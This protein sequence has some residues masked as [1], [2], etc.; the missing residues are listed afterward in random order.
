M[1]IDRAF[2][3]LFNRGFKLS[4]LSRQAGFFVIFLSVVIM[5]RFAVNIYVFSLLGSGLS[6]EE[7]RKLNVENLTL[8]GSL[9]ITVGAFMSYGGIADFLSS[10][11]LFLVPVGRTG[12]FLLWIRRSLF[13]TASAVFW[14]VGFLSALVLVLN[15]GGEGPWILLV[16][17]AVV[18]A[19]TAGGYSV[20]CIVLW[21]LKSKRE[22]M[23][24]VIVTLLVFLVIA[25][26]DARINNG[27]V[28]LFL[29]S[30][31]KL[32]A[33]PFMII[34]AGLTV[35]TASAALV[36]SLFKAT[37]LIVEKTRN[38]YSNPVLKFYLVNIP[39]IPMIVTFSVEAAVVATNPDS[40]G[41]VRNMVIVLF[42][43]WIVWYAAF[44]FK[45]EMIFSESFLAPQNRKTRMRVYLP[46][47]ILHTAASLLLP[48]VYFI[49][50]GAGEG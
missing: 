1:N 18:A 32:T 23:V 25:N 14:T 20:A 44:L 38:R 41:F 42:F 28:R 9:F 43:L 19:A 26:P 29:F 34:F 2:R 21:M 5:I 10:E 27:E 16:D 3:V 31:V 6:V 37:R 15:A 35:F 12:L 7:L 46:S 11:R 30:G 22:E 48:V 50:G 4:A 33:P 49:T 39:L 13:G 8:L 36:T 40:G 45:G 17:W 47:M 24:T